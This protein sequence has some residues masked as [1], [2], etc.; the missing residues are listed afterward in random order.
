MNALPEPAGGPARRIL[1]VEDDPTVAEVVTG[2]L[3]RAGHRVE[4]VTDGLTALERA[5]AVRP[6][7]VVLDLMLPGLDGLEVCRRLRMGG[8][9]PLPVVMLTAR[10]EEEHRILGLEVGADD[11]LTKPFSPRELVLRVAS[12]LRRAEAPPPTAPAVLRAGDLVVDPAARR[13]ERGGR[14]LALTGR[15]F[16]LLAFLLRHPF[17]VF[18]RE[19]LLRHVWGWEF[20]DTSTVTVHV[21][22]LREKVEDDPAT[23][24][25]ISTVWSAGYR[26]DPP[27]DGARDG[28]LRP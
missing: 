14:E 21:R 6:R 24:T 18:S 22:R 5:A 16:D 1:L 2:Y 19:E 17:R 15:E 28:G 27:R 25:L 9:P 10:G 26:F 11:Y 4:R 3:T 20:G 23:P 13:A 8:G 12:V 7:L